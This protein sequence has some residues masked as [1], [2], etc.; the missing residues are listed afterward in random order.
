[1]NLICQD[2]C[3][4]KPFN[5]FGV[6]VLVTRSKLLKWQ[7]KVAIKNIYRKQDRMNGFKILRDYIK[8][9]TNKYLC[10]KINLLLLLPIIRLVVKKNY[11]YK[12]PA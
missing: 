9:H 7:I 5:S 8:G 10:C 6:S 12:T 11:I 4:P 3:F 1:M 2:N